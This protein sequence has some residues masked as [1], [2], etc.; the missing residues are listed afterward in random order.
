MNLDDAY[1]IDGEPSADDWEEEQSLPEGS[2]ERTTQDA[3]TDTPAAGAL[4]GEKPLSVPRKRSLRILVPI[5]L[6]LVL[7]AAFITVLLW[8]LFHGSLLDLFH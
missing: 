1:E 2:A 7:L 3:R 6:A 4:D 5:L 8:N